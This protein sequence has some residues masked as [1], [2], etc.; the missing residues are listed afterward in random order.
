MN[1]LFTCEHN[2]DTY[3]CDTNQIMKGSGILQM[4]QECGRKQMECHRPSFNEFLDDG[5]AW[6]ISRLDMV[7]Y[8][9]IKLGD[10]LNLASWACDSSRAT[11]LRMYQAKRDNKVVAEISSQWVVVDYETRKILKVTDVDL[12]NYYM[13]E[14]H[15]VIGEKFRIPKDTD[16]E[17]VG[18]KEIMYSDLDTNGHMNNTYYLDVI[19]NYVPELCAGTHRVYSARVHFAK[20]ASLGEVLTVTRCK[21]GE[22]KYLFRTLK[23]NGEKNIDAEITVIPV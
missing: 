20:E 3:S 19:S 8:D 6:M 9:E 12:S 13:G 23:P 16:F 10:N 7:A 18:K 11:F 4:C 21:T 5:K 22:G 15:D 14:Y 1:E 2:V 17:E